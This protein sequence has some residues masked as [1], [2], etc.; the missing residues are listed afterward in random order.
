MFDITAMSLLECFI[1]PLLS[2]GTFIPNQISSWENT[3][4][5]I[6]RSHFFQ[7]DWGDHY[8]ITSSRNADC[9]SYNGKDLQHFVNKV[10]TDY[11]V[12]MYVFYFLFTT[13]A[14]LFGSVGSLMRYFKL[15]N[16]LRH[17]RKFRIYKGIANFMAFCVSVPSF[18]AFKVHYGDCVTVNGNLEWL[19]NDSFRT[20]GSAGFWMLFVAPCICMINCGE[21]WVTCIIRLYT[22]G[23]VVMFFAEA[24]AINTTFWVAWQMPWNLYLFL[25]GAF[26]V[27]LVC[28][29]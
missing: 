16:D 23:I 28:K 9:G 21:N 2:V 19:M 15:E 1:F 26:Q 5:F 10:G 4:S 8:T 25:D 14:M 27:L 22:F 18:Y 7:W 29:K 20:L 13:L 24:V 6:N 12:A 3:L 11:I 17:Q